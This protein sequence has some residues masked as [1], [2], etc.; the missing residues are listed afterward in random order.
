MNNAAQ[1]AGMF[2]INWLCLYLVFATLP[3]IELLGLVTGNPSSL[4]VAHALA[5][6]A[7]GVILIA[8]GAGTRGLPWRGARW[9]FVG[10]ISVSSPVILYLA[11]PLSAPAVFGLD[12]VRGIV[13]LLVGAVV[14]ALLERASS[15]YRQ[16]T[17][18]IVGAAALLWGGTCVYGMLLITL[19]TLP[20]VYDPVLY[21]FENILGFS[22][23]GIFSTIMWRY[24]LA[25]DA[26]LALYNFLNIAVILAAASEFIY[27]PDR[28][29]AGLFLQFLVVAG[30]GYPLYYVMPAVD[31]ANFF[32]AAFPHH[33]PAV[34][35][36]AMQAVTVPACAPAFAPRNT[37]PSL[38]ATW[39]IIAVLALRYS[40]LWHKI[41]G[42]LFLVAIVISTLG[43]GGHYTVDWLCALP[44]VLL[45]RG[46][47]AL[48]L[49]LGAAARR[50][51]ILVGAALVGCW[52]IA[53][54]GAP[55]TLAYPDMIRLLAVVSIVFPVWGEVRL[56]R[57][58]R[59]KGVPPAHA[60][61]AQAGTQASGLSA[62]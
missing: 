47:S 6:E 13:A 30:I 8:A 31:P 34:Q 10:W 24:S 53:V 50:N 46:V 17:S 1:K 29:R 26:I 9:L 21:R 28:R 59:G 3:V 20:L 12:F 14:A 61:R 40:P 55:L 44:L 43:L 41:L 27:T 60:V 45:V 58:E 62:P 38:H 35:S 4:P 54:R 25:G 37:M 11:L 57:A 7:L 5:A 2:D 39:A 16:C 42:A 22:Q 51:A 19:G 23:T 32:C 15:R 49:P 48:H 52:I 33:L 36:V 56:A 18:F